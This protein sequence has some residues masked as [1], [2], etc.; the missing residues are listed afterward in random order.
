MDTILTVGLPWILFFA[1]H[2]WMAANG[3]KDWVKRNFPSMKRW[4]RL[5]YNLVSALLF[6]WA[7]YYLYNA[8]A[9]YL[10]PTFPIVQYVSWAM[11]A[12]G[13]MVILLCFRNYQIGE[14]IGTQQLQSQPAEPTLNTS[15]LNQYVRHPLYF[16][17]FL[18][19][20][21]YLFNAFTL[22]HLVFATTVFAYLII[23]TLL[24]EQK[25]EKQFGAAYQQYKKEVKMLIPFVL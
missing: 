19:V 13:V 3:V 18:T 7:G 8:P 12:A 23:G 17:T 11:M 6:A 10:I 15:G 2:S 20:M 21:G 1:V 14:F 24:E 25:L 16:G 5:L 9:Q 4:Y 22:A